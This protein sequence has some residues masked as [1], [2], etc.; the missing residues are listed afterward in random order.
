MV[1]VRLGWRD[2]DRY[3]LCWRH[4]PGFDRGKGL[5]R[6]RALDLGSTVTWLEAESPRVS[7]P[8]HGVV[9]T[10]VPWARHGARFTTEFEDQVAW[11]VTRSAQSTA[12]VL[13]RISWRSVAAIVTRV[14]GSQEEG[15]TSSPTSSGSGSTRLGTARGSAT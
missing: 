7:C 10:A 6:W 15:E 2:R 14:V 1:T 12:A 3:G 8:E 13:L 11:L 9:V 5:R 4:C